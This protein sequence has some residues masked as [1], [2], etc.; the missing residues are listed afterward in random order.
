MHAQARAA[1]AAQPLASPSPPSATPESPPLSL[2][3]QQVIPLAG[4]AGAGEA[5]GSAAAWAHEARMLHG[6]RHRCVVHLVGVAV[7]GDKAMLITEFMV[8][9]RAVLARYGHRC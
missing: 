1:P 7:H 8:R 4:A 2:P 9:R 6:L 3:H 5:G